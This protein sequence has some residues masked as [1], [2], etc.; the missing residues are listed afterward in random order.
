ML[1]KLIK[2]FIV[3]FYF[4]V[5]TLL[6]KNSAKKLNKQELIPAE[7]TYKVSYPTL[8]LRNKDEVQRKPYDGSHWLHSPRIHSGTCAYPGT[9]SS[10]HI[11]R[12]GVF[13]ALS[14]RFGHSPGHSQLSRTLN[15]MSP[16][17]CGDSQ[18]GGS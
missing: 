12:C 11:H 10:D 8:R 4:Y 16:A 14:I 15:S 6:T 1:K 13:A 9:L 3:Y 18:L 2:K 7:A 5:L 17:N